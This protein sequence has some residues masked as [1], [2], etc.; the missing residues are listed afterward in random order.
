VWLE[1]AVIVISRVVAP[2]DQSHDPPVT[3]CGPNLTDAPALTETEA[4]CCQAPPPTWRYGVI[5]DGVQPL[6]GVAVGRLV[7]EGPAVA[8]GRGR[9][10]GV[11]PPPHAPWSLQSDAAAGGSQPTCEVCPWMQR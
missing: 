4:V 7:G 3:G 11:A 9:D 6:R 10:V 8:V 1:L 2:V 5:A